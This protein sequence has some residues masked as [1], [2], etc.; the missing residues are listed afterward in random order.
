MVDSPEDRADIQRDQD[1][2]EAVSDR[3]FMQYNKEK[4]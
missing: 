1:R 2:W 4:C 3:N